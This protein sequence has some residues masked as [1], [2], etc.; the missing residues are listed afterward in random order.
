[1]TR[2][3]FAMLLGLSCAVPAFGEHSSNGTAGGGDGIQLTV[4]Y[5]YQGSQPTF[6][7]GWFGVNGGSADVL[8]P[9]TGRL[10]A[11][12]EFSG[13]H[14][15]SLPLADSGLTLLTYMAGPRY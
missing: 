10:G 6:G 2:V 1:M 3:I 5:L 7:G 4:G 9:V 8:V 13:A 11:V 15:G 14:A 12:G